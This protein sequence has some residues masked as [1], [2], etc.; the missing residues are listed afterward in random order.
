MGYIMGYT[1]DNAGTHSGPLGSETLSTSLKTAVLTALASTTK[2]YTWV[3]QF[4]E[5]PLDAV[6]SGAAC[7]IVLGNIHL[8]KDGSV[9]VS[10]SLFYGGTGGGGTTFVLKPIDGVWTVTGTTGPAWVS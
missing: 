2:K 4:D 10:A 5:I 6:H 9:H 8:Q 7:Q 3:D 1:D